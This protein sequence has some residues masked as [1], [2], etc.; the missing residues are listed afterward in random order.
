MTDVECK[1]GLSSPEGEQAYEVLYITL[2]NVI[3]IITV[4]YASIQ[5]TI[6]LLQNEKRMKKMETEVKNE[7]N[8]SAEKSKDNANNV[9]TVT[10]SNSKAKT[11]SLKETYSLCKMNANEWIKVLVRASMCFFGILGNNWLAFRSI[12]KSRSQLRTNDVLF[13]NLAVS[14][15]ITNYL[16]DLPDT[17]EFVVHLT[18]RY[19]TVFSFCSNLS[20]TSSILT[21]MFITVYWHQK[22]V[23]ALKRG[24]APVQMDNLCLITALLTGSWA[25]ATIF[26]IPHFFFISMGT[27]NQ[28]FDDCMEQASSQEA[29][30]AYEMVYLTL[31]NL[32]PIIGIVFASIQIA[33]T[34]VQNERRIKN[35]TNTCNR[36]GNT[37]IKKAPEPTSKDLTSNAA[38]SVQDQRQAV[39]KSK[40]KNSSSVGNQCYPQTQL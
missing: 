5:I 8:T 31:A 36:G 23:G 35:S 6:T 1:D 14:N 29:R 30:Q 9:S 4:L 15:L 7:G 2:V 3:P 28:S 33:V 22:L 34:L 20:E 11:G 25:F 16:V 32:A 18:R 19:C 26:S 21:T 13:V 12:P 37:K 39:Q 27:L 17:L 38:N 24:G 40:A 10:K